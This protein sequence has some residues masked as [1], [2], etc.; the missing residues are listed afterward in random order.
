MIHPRSRRAR[1]GGVILEFSLAFPIFIMLSLGT[2]VLGFGVS[3]FQLVAT[4]AREGARWAS[5]HGAEYQQTTG[6]QAASATDVYNQAILPRATGLLTS[7]LTYSVNWAPNN[8]PGGTVTVAINYQW[9]PSAYLG[10][11]NLASTSVMTVEY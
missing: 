1:R 5:V 6:K 2:T 8:Q 10:T 11:V 7:N 3:Q 4:L 9:V